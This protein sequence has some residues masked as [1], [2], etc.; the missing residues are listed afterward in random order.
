MEFPKETWHYIIEIISPW[1]ALQLRS[2]SKKLYEVVSSFQ[3][4]WYRQFC[5]YLICQKKRPAMFKTGCKRKH[6]Q[7][8]SI[9][10][11]NV[12][13]EVQLATQL[14]MHVSELCN[15]DITPFATENDDYKCTNASHY[16]YEIPANRFLIPLDPNDYKPNEQSYLYR[17]LIHNYRQQR[18]RV[19]RYN[20]SDIKT[21]LRQVQDELTKQQKEYDR[22]LD[23]CQREI[24][25]FKT[26][27]KFL[28]GVYQQLERL[29]NN[30][31]FHN[32]RSR[33]YNNEFK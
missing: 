26:R 27:Q 10:C 11:L 16:M 21:Q 33:T 28:K 9:E 5:W 3:S 29:D 13:Q 19:S 8:H 14:N 22:L 2:A 20:K 4:Y 6:I 7:P 23:Q 31:V 15:I 30:K 32:Q 25:K 1:D 18:Q 12:Q 24:Q 17:F